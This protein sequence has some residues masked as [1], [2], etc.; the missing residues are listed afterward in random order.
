M[1]SAIADTAAAVGELLAVAEGTAD[2]V[3]VLSVLSVD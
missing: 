3:S 1:Q 2:V